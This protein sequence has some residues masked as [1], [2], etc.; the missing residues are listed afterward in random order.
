MSFFKGQ[1]I[2]SIDSKG[3]VN[4]PAKMRKAI[5]EDANGIFILTKGTDKCIQAY[6]WDEWRK[7]EENFKSLNQYDP[8]QRYFL[9]SLLMWSEEVT[10]DSQQRLSVPKKLSEYAGIA[11]KVCMVG[12]VDHI[13]L[14]D[15]DTFDKYMNGF[16]ESY[17]EVAQKVMGTI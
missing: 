10:L 3:R 11:G 14:W 13:E 17:E 1:E 15:P 7:Y 9:R 12:M 2:Y 16:D 8:K 6:P 4:V 5:S